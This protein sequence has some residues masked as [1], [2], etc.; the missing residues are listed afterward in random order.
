MSSLRAVPSTFV[1]VFMPKSVDMKVLARLDFAL[2]LFFF[3]IGYWPV[4]LAWIVACGCAVI[5]QY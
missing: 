1:D 3:F 4:A 5:A 2:A